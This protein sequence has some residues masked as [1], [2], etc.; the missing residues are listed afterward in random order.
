MPGKAAVSAEMPR[1]P[2]GRLQQ[3]ASSFEHISES[4]FHFTSL[5]LGLYLVRRVSR[6]E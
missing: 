6:K 1:L 3:R 4:T 5:N 2:A